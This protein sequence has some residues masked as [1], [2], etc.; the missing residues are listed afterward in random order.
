MDMII[1]HS[2]EDQYVDLCTGLRK[3]DVL[4]ARYPYKFFP[5]FTSES[6]RGVFQAD[7]MFKGSTMDLPLTKNRFRCKRV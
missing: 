7:A 2:L 1:A 3:N 4:F 6:S 5:I